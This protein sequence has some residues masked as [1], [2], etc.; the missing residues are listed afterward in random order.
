MYGPELAESLVA[1]RR[2]AELPQDPYWILDASLS[3]FLGAATSA[4]QGRV[5]P[6]ADFVGTSVRLLILTDAISRA[7][8]IEWAGVHYILGLAYEQCAFVISGLR[9]PTSVQDDPFQHDEW[10]RLALAVLHYLAGGYRVQAVAALRRMRDIGER[11]QVATYLEAN[12]HFRALFDARVLDGGGPRWRRILFSDLELPDPVEAM[13]NRLARQVRT[14]RGIVLSQLGRETPEAWLA[15]RNITTD[16]G[17]NFWRQY[18]AS[19]ESRGIVSFSREQFGRG[20]DTWLQ[21]QSDLLVVLP[22][23][24]GK[25]LV[26]EL[27]TAL[28]LAAGY[29]CIWKI[30]R[31]HV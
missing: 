16:T 30:G 24:A 6:A 14:Q 21:L 20:F 2:A 3:C 5:T 7:T 18:L 9:A 15:Q 23:G 10:T 17:Y 8:G 31:A 28:S 12:A 26:G 27:R 13:L 29:S 1:L 11:A 25:S 22:T 4:L 19:L